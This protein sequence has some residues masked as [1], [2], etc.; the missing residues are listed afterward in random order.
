[1]G[2]NDG[3][4]PVTLQQMLLWLWRRKLPWLRMSTGHMYSDPLPG[5]A[6]A[7]DG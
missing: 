5:Q 2:L 1:M 6:M 7:G 4:A 3:D